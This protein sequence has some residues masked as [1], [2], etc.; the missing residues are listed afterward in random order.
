MNFFEGD[1][2]PLQERHLRN[3]PL[4]RSQEVERMLDSGEKNSV[5]SAVGTQN[6]KPGNTFPVN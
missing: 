4:R 3:R 5:A 2:N 6:G 1:I